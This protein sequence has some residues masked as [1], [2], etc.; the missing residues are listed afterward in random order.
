MPGG[1]GER[2]PLDDV[3]EGPSSPTTS[4]ISHFT[5]ISERP[6]NPRWQPPPP[7]PMPTRTK[8]SILLENNPDFDLRA[9]GG[10]GGRMP[11]T[12]YP[13]P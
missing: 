12:R 5:S 10:R 9:G 4:D 1:N 2:T 6:V 13:I 3:E 11:A 8:Q 7:P